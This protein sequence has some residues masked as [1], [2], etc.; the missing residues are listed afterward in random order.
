MPCS[1]PTPLG[2]PTPPALPTPRLLAVRCHGSFGAGVRE[3][4]RFGVRLDLIVGSFGVEGLEVRVCLSVRG[5]NMR[6]VNGESPFTTS[7]HDL[8][9][10]R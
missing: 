8:E 9:G 4:L 1:P 2:P 10:D 3:L 7:I 5:G 6:V